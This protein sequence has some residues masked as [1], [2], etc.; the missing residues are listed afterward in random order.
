V[1]GVEQAIHVAL[2][3]CECFQQPRFE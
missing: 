1:R 3:V 2:A